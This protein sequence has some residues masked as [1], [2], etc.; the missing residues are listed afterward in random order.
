M[1]SL[2]VFFEPKS[3]AIIGATRTPGEIGYEILKNV[4]QSFKGQI[5]PINP[6][7]TEIENLTTYNSL[8]N[9]ENQ[10]DLAIIVTKPS[11]V[12]H[13]L[14]ESKKNRVKAAIIVSSG[15]SEK[16]MEKVNAHIKKLTKDLKFRVIGPNS[17]GLYFKSFDAI[18]LPKERLKR[19]PEG[20]ISFI[21]QSGAIGATLMDLASSEGIG[22]NKFVAVG[23]AVDINEIE[24]LDY[25]GKDMQTRCIVMYIESTKNGRELIDKAKKIVR[26][27]PIII[28][29][30]GKEEQG[31]R[32]VQKHIGQTTS[33]ASIYSAAFKQAGI[34][35][36]R[37]TYELFD[38]AKSL[39]NQPILKNN[40]I[41]ILTN[42]GGFG[43]LASDEASRLGLEI[44]PL[45]K[46]T[47]KNM[48]HIPPHVVKQ[49][50]LDLGGDANADMYQIALNAMLKDQNISGIV[51]IAL[52]QTPTLEERVVNVIRESKLHGKP[53]T[54]CMTG[55]DYTKKFA[56]ELE[57][58]GIPVY[59]TPERAV[60]ALNILLK[61]N[62]ILKRFK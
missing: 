35:E 16:E 47:I 1:S 21:T 37:T 3:V 49:N 60:R 58:Y 5:Y 41:G 10:V 61:Y 25:F 57:S 12:V 40:K 14:T 53:I 7:L 18:Y 59:P 38:Y 39:A 13:F 20:Y 29:K 19:P 27:K 8:Y 11:E 4:K 45:S 36:A 33:H 54:V 52:L 34:I 55:S 26:N 28:L 42:A 2:D 17:L 24:L 48:K 43:I 9:I 56:I 22:I 51:S 31:I 15:F 32:A 62:K 50:P 23:N 44:F 46:E 6:E 30:A